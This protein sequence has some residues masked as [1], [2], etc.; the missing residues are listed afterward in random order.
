MCYDRLDEC[1]VMFWLY[2]YVAL[3]LVNLWMGI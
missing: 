2:I 3:Y 1:I